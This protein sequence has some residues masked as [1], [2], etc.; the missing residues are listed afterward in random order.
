MKDMGIK[1]Y[2]FVIYLVVIFFS[3]I[4]VWYSPVLFKG[5]PAEAM[6]YE[7]ILARNY[8]DDGIY[9]LEDDLNIVVAPELVESRV[10]VSSMGNKFST[11]SYSLI[12]KLF[13]WQSWDKL[14][15][16]SAAIYALA[17]I[18]FS[19]T[20]YF[21]FGLWPAVL[22][23]IIYAL[24]PFN[25][26]TSQFVGFYEFS[27][28][29]FSIFTFSYFWGRKQKLSKIY[30]ILAGLFLALSCLSREAIL[31]FLPIFFSWLWFYKRKKDIL[32]VF[33][34][35]GLI[36]AIFWLPGIL[37][38]SGNNDYL[39][40]FVQNNE[41]LSHTDFHFYGHIYPDPYTYH[42]NKE[43]VESQ[44]N[45]EISAED[46]DLIYRIGRWKVGA[47]LGLR[48]ISFFERLVVGSTNLSRHISK[49]FAFELIGG[50]LIFLLALI[51][52]GQLKS[53]N[54]KIYYLFI[55]W[56]IALPVLLSYFV[57]AIRSHLM[58]LG[59]AIAGLVSLGL[60]SLLPLLK[61]YYQLKKFSKAI[62]LFI[63][64]IT[65]YNLVLANHVYWGR[66]YDQMSNLETRYL[67]EKI[68]NFSEEIK[69]EDVIAVGQR[70]LHPTL[71]YLTGK[72]IV[73]FHES[74]VNNL[75][76]KK[77]LQD[78]FDKFNVKYITGYP[79]ATTDLITRNSNV[80]NI[81]S[82]PR[83]ENIEIPVSY[84][85]MWFLNLIK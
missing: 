50:P 42:F 17:A 63:I 47:N 74:T 81:A 20:I 66:A 36:L 61:N 29:Y 56:F 76:E 73:F 8:A 55:S 11:I 41:Q 33:I 52:L 1:K 6:S 51:G 82:W 75:V 15:L 2:F 9:G 46:T 44:L 45:Q 70:G 35:V 83:R 78:A 19:I 67:A 24:L 4:A 26:H 84:G 64:L 54:K 27:L 65:F 32:A 60:V 34:P 68:I 10:N 62:Y 38:F 3:I 16:I 21:L 39:K 79:D 31:V 58:D 14:V 18:I 28:L 69:A 23:P 37:G 7:I 5:Y 49:Y 48:K 85:K 59:F 57:L 13:G 53:L 25:W 30:L 80:K 77:E 43:D 71:N 40:L 72:S 22:F 12:F